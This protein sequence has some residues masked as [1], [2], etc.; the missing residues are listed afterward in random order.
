MSLD[1]R[2]IS[3]ALYVIKVTTNVNLGFPQAYPEEFKQYI[4]TIE[5][6]AVDKSESVSA[7][8]WQ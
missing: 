1:K 2:E 3:E 8:F 6:C 7:T 5:F 4:T